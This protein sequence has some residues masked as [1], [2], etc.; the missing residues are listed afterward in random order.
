MTPEVQEQ[1]SQLLFSLIALSLLYGALLGA[2]LTL[3]F[4]DDLIRLFNF[5]KTFF[6]KLKD[7]KA[8]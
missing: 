5:V 6:K 7:R 8:N 3:F 1:F 4:R 2:L